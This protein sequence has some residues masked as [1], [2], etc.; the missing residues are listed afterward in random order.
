MQLFAQ[1]LLG[2]SSGLPL[3]AIGSTLKAW[4]TEAGLDLS[5]IG[6]FSLVGMPYTLKFLWAPVFDRFSLPFLGRRRGWILLLQL[7]L[8]ILFCSFFIFDPKTQL[9]AIAAI[10]VL[11]AFISASQDIVVDALRRDSLSD[12]QMGFGTAL[13]TNGYRLGMLVS[14]ALALYLAESIPWNMVYPIISCSFIIGILGVVIIKEPIQEHLSPSTLK[15]AVTGPFKDFFTR[16]NAIFILLFILLY[17][18]G[19]SLASEMS[20]P[21]LLKSGYTK[22]AIAAIAK[23]IGLAATLIGA[24]LGGTAMLRLGVVRSLWIFGL[25]QAV[26]ILTFAFL[27]SIPPSDTALAIVV[28]FE[29]MCFGMGTTAYSAYMATV[30]SKRFSASQFALLT[31]IMGIP[32]V[33]FGSSSGVLAEYFGWKGYFIFCATMAIPGMLMLLIIAPWPDSST[34]NSE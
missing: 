14:G 17:K 30:C 15:E 28:A 9:Q 34:K 7:I 24:L 5:T 23:T 19:D 2:F 20:T 6:F 3:L 16:K 31:S 27:A 10:A 1:L 4:L 12:E 18:F 13:F 29:N 25:L 11:I 8:S 21:F 22:S 26:S 32:R 33:I